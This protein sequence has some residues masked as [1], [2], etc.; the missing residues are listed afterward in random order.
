MKGAKRYC[1]D[2]RIL[3]RTSHENRAEEVIGLWSIYRVNSDASGNAWGGGSSRVPDA[4]FAVACS[5]DA[6][7]IA[8]DFSAALQ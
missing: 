4:R 5:G 7:R 1:D 3:G 8:N 6:L 2:L